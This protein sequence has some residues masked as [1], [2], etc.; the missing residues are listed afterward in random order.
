MAVSRNPKFEW[1]DRLLEATDLTPTARFIGFVLAT[2]WNGGT[3]ETPFMSTRE[4]VER[5]GLSDKT[6]RNARKALEEAGWITIVR[7]GHRLGDTTRATSYRL[8]LPPRRSLGWGAAAAVAEAA[9]QFQPVPLEP[10]PVTGAGP[11][12]NW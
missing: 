5:T 7:R 1:H 2:K 3:E 10:Q 12:G 9:A 4:I 8:T 6:V 11:T